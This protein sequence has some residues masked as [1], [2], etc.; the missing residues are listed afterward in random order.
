MDTR[1]KLRLLGE[2]A[3]YDAGDDPEF[4]LFAPAAG[5]GRTADDAATAGASADAAISRHLARIT[6]PDG[7]CATVLKVLQTS[8][9]QNNCN[10]CAFRAGRDTP[11]AHFT[12]DELA[13]TFDLMA[14]AG[15]VQGIFLS[16]GI[17]GTARTM[18][19]MLATAE[20]IRLKYAYRGYLH[21]KLLPGCDAAH[22]ERAVELAD[23]VSV[24]LEAPTV[25]SLAA[26]APR[27]ALSDLI[28]PLRLAHDALVRRRAAGGGAPALGDVRLGMSTQFVVGPG[29]ESDC[30]LLLTAQAL[31]REVG[32][33][34]AY[35]SKFRPVH[36]TPLADATP[37]DPRREFRLYQADFLLRRY[38][39]KAEELPFEEGGGLSRAVDPKVAWARAHP[40]QFPIEVN[41]AGLEQLM[42]APGIGPHSARSIVQARRQGRL[43]ELGELRRLGVRAD[44]AAPYVTLAG[45]RPPYQLPLPL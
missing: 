23:R 1:E 36:G 14:R 40:E 5:D 10:Y 39:F 4:G 41:S 2:A 37:T 8:S 43:T 42:K 35:Y 18:D 20:L 3:Q 9:C 17:I 30:D 32:L 34:R 12:P 24:N 29:G 25:E 27:K 19:E 22:I 45:R 13:R 26:L 38:H 21:L 6:R 16:S 33:A 28:A 31:Y 15:A 7:R 44:Q 11:R